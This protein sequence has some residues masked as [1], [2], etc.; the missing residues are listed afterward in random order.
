VTKPEKNSSGGALLTD[1]Y[2]LTMAHLY[3]ELGLHEQ[4]VQFDHFFRHYPDYGGH[5]AGYCINAGLAWFL[6]WLEGASFAAGDIRFLRDQ[7]GQSGRPL[8][9]RDFLAWLADGF[10]LDAVHIHAIPEGRVVHPHIPLT[11]VQ[12]PLAV[13]QIIE[14]ALLNHLNYQTL[15]AT[16]ASRLR[17]SARG[18][19]IL[20]FG[21][22][23]GHGLGANAGARAALIGGADFSSNV[24]LS[25]QVGLAPKGTHAHSMVQALMANGMSE[26]EAF[27][28]YAGL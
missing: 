13:A 8:F 1:H 23:R 9:S 20:E 25:R 28:A 15:V 26:Q 5:R 2:Q 14:T 22:R 27:R 24:G 16:K 7:V 4:P 6:D 21:L 19:S 12:G 17:Q 3:F 11:L 10:S 18:Q